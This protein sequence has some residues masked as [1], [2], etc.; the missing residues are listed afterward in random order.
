MALH[1]K[2]HWLQVGLKHVE[3][4]SAVDQASTIAYPSI[5]AATAVFLTLIGG[6]HSIPYSVAMA[7]V[8]DGLEIEA[9]VRSDNAQR[10]GERT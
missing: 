1:T 2:E 6:L 4:F 8:K 7:L 10:Y 3:I 5:K 9:K